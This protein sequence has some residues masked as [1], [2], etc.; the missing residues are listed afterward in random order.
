MT[1]LLLHSLFLVCLGQLSQSRNLPT[2]K[3]AI[4][5]S[6]E[7]DGP[8]APLDLQTNAGPSA[9]SLR[10][11][12]QMTTLIQSLSCF[13]LAGH[14]FPTTARHRMELST[15]V[16]HGGPQPSGL[17]SAS[18]A[19]LVSSSTW[20][21]NV[22]FPPHGAPLTPPSYLTNVTASRKSSLRPSPLPRYPGLSYKHSHP[23]V[24]SLTALPTMSRY[25]YS[26]I[27]WLLFAPACTFLKT[28]SHQDYAEKKDQVG[29]YYH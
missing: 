18:P 2:Q 22:L 25:I 3:R 1:A 20:P 29:V 23:H 19:C 16:V 9:C 13:R 15:H 4:L 14:W 26:V 5:W 24:I 8:Q 28:G 6:Q 21:F 17:L 10:E 7:C 12:T 11:S 27:I